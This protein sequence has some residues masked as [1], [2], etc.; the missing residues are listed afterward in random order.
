VAAAKPAGSITAKQAIATAW[1]PCEAATERLL[2]EAAAQGQ[3]GAGDL[4]QVQ[5]AGRVS[6]LPES[7]G[8]PDRRRGGGKF[9][10]R[11]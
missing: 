11:S 2:A 6:G 1:M 8:A 4:K 3:I 9:I 5:I 7:P 10:A